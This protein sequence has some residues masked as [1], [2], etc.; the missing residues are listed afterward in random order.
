MNET[1]PAVRACG[2]CSRCCVDLVIQGLC[3]A[4]PPDGVKPAGRPCPHLSPS[5]FVDAAFRWLG[6]C[7]DYAARPPACSGYECLWRLLGPDDDVLGNS[8]RPD[9]LG[10]VFS[11]HLASEL[12][13]PPRGEPPA[14]WLVVTA[15]P[16]YGPDGTV[17]RPVSA[18]PAAMDAVRC[19][20]LAGLA[21]LIDEEYAGG[22]AV[23][24]EPLRK[25]TEPFARRLAA[26]IERPQD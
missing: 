11:T 24:D 18:N 4:G 20:R 16:V 6:W 1:T 14:D 10:A 5:G 25:P 3:H 21:V 15:C 23:L 2:T 12:H 7:D 13:L 19:L 9:L 22:R 26:A 17:R 8:A